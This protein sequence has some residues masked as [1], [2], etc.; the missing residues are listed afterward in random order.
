MQKEDPTGY[1]KWQHFAEGG[2]LW[3]QVH[4]GR[5]YKYGGQGLPQDS[6]KGLEWIQRA[7]EKGNVDTYGEMAEL[8]IR[9]F[10][11]EKSDK[12]VKRW[13]VMVRLLMQETRHN[14]SLPER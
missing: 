13:T 6:E 8:H 9:G 10:G 7:A 5:I 1:R 14:S 11:V 4:L 2:K 12:E 3:A